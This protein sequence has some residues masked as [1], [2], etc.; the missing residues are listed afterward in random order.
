M[1]LKPHDVD[2][3]AYVDGELEL[4]RQL[5]MESRIE[6]DP[7]LHA[8]VQRLRQLR[9]SVRGA[10]NYHA[11]PARLRTRIGF[12]AAAAP[13]AADVE[14]PEPA[15]PGPAQPGRV[16]R[17]PALPAGAVASR[18]W[19]P[20][21]MAIAAG[22]L[23]VWGL[24]LTPWPAGRD[25]PLLRDVVA[26]HVRATLSERLIDVASSDQHTVKPW[27]SARLDY[28]PPVTPLAETGVTFL[29]ARVDYLDGRQVAVMVYKQRQHVVDVYVWP[30]RGAD[31]EVRDA[32][33]RGFNVKRWKQGEMTYAMVSDLNRD[34][35][36]VLAQALQRDTPTR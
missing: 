11:A 9:A 10:A 13:A 30:T 2:V 23:L 29:G 35:L 5:D 32:S 18:P 25:D 19:R 12:P 31:P 15:T 36:G 28:S 20:W 22:G 4:S 1:M 26:S 21:G 7:A 17:N 34:E 33:P 8:E 14:V 24:V 16:N 3:N 6:R 27:L